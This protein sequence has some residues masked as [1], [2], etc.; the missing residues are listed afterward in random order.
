MPDPTDH[1]HEYWEPIGQYVNKFG[2]LERWVDACLSDLMG[3]P[4]RQT[5]MHLLS[6]IDFYSRANLLKTF[7]RKTSVENEMNDL[8]T[9]I[10]EQNSFRNH[11]V[12]GDWIA[13]PTHSDFE[14]E[15][16]KFN[17][18]RDSV[19]TLA[20]IPIDVIQTNASKLIDL[21]PKV[22]KTARAAIA[23]RASHRAIFHRPQ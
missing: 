21:I 3:V 18:N 17:L 23:E 10:E 8:F 4:Y 19:S 2:A 5:G 13:I 1:F 12:R 6:E 20:H 9:E 11:L 15:F 14:H 16:Q 7:C 22:V